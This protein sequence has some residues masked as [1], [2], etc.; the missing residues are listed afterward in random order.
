MNKLCTLFELVSSSL[1]EL[2][3]AQFMRVLQKQECQSLQLVSGSSESP[4]KYNTLF[5]KKNK[6]KTAGTLFKIFYLQGVS[7]HI[8]IWVYE[9]NIL[10]QFLQSNYGNVFTICW[11]QA[12]VCLSATIFMSLSKGVWIFIDKQLQTW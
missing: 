2:Q 6:R 10:V 8:H 1:K 4:N 12:F 9:T 11:K 3:S 7:L 5:L